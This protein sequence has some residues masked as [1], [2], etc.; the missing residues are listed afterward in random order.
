MVSCVSAMPDRSAASP[1]IPCRRL[2]V[3]DLTNSYR[4]RVSKQASVDFGRYIANLIAGSSYPN[5]SAFARDAGVSPSSVSRWINGH[6][7][8]APRLIP[9]VAAKLGRPVSELLAMAYPDESTQ[10]TEPPPL[11]EVHP[12]VGRLGRWLAPDSP[13]PPEGRQT[14]EFY[15]GN[16]LDAVEAQYRDRMKRRPR[17]A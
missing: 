6:E 2:G 1:D 11:A 12:L 13:L 16:L 8:P 14:I 4:L 3:G 5:A 15:V 9:Q 10:A 7:R 17:S